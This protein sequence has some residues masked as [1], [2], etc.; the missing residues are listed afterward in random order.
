MVWGYRYWCHRHDY[1]AGE[2]KLR[3]IQIIL[4]LL[5]FAGTTIRSQP[6]PRD[7]LTEPSVR[8][9]VLYR[10]QPSSNPVD[11]LHYNVVLGI[12]PDEKKIKGQA[13]LTVRILDR[14]HPFYLH[15]AGLT[16]HS[17]T[18]N[19]KDAKIEREG[20]RIFFPA[21]F[22]DS[23]NIIIEYSGQ[24][25]NDGYGGFFFRENVIYS[26]GE[27]LNSYPPS[28]LR[29]WIPSHDVP[30]DKALLDMR[31]SAP[32]PFQVVSNG[33]LMSTETRDSTTT[34]HWR[35]IH[36]I[37]PYL[38]A[39]AIADYNVL[40]KKYVSVTG[41]TIPLEFYVFPEQIADARQDWI[42]LPQMFTI[43]EEMFSPYPFN[44][45]SMALVPV[46]GAMEH[47]T[48]TS[49]S[50][51]LITGD[52]RYDYIMAHE[53][54]HHW[55]GNYV[56]LSDWREIWL[57]EGFATYSE[58]LYFEALSGPDKLA[59]YMQEQAGEYLSETNRLGH[60]SIYDPDHLWGGTVYEKGAWVLHMLRWT[61]GDADFFSTLKTFLDR[62]AY[63]NA[64]IADFISIAENNSGQQL[65]WFFDQWIYQPGYPDLDIR[66]NV[67]A[68]GDKHLVNIEFE[69]K[70]HMYSPFILPLEIALTTLQKTILDTVC[71]EHEIQSFTFEMDE[72]PT[73]LRID[74]NNWALLT[75]DIIS[76]P[77]PHNFVP[78]QW[79]LA[80]N[81]PNPFRQGEKTKI[82]FQVARQN[83]PH[84]VT[85]A[86]YNVLGQK[87][88]TLVH[89]RYHDGVY[90]TVWDGT[91]Q[92]GLP[93][94]KGIYVLKMSSRDLILQQKCVLLE[95]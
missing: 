90:Q 30:A 57:N 7:K 72:R 33:L 14:S 44:R 41:D 78:H 1:I 40:T 9:T 25:L 94:S 48:M 70:Q 31:V 60:F 64:Q 51:V 47:Q 10:I 67:N 27:G 45:Y 81:Y 43:Y 69:Q 50:P 46:G 24:P 58:A 63:G 95:R 3:R 71:L 29:Y 6:V 11:V 2:Q 19:E 82:D 42:N 37:A 65:D 87:V 20:D 84:D 21:Q 18:I 61:I 52:N 93:V 54:A 80:P 8:K 79:E 53:L 35:E 83:A 34:F 86:V 89:R 32:E 5:F 59:R 38:I 15:L 66:W 56:T 13:H 92:A 12:F 22:L 88:K 23:L 76:E 62:Y 28:M 91:N 73:E 4:F 17:V 36:P 68:I 39:V 74:P 75:F 49:Y 26:Q 16:I 85:L 77:L 55:W